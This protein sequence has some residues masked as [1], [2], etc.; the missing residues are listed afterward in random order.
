MKIN[1]LSLFS[2]IGRIKLG[3][4]LENKTHDAVP[5]KKKTCQSQ[6]AYKQYNCQY[7]KHQP[8]NNNY[9]QMLPH[10]R[11]RQ[12]PSHSTCTSLEPQ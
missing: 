2:G 7:H 5:I 9:L 12:V 4:S 11:Q 3:F 6:K 8:I 10:S 1:V